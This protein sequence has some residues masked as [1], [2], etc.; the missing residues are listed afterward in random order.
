MSSWHQQLL[1]TVILVYHNGLR[2]SQNTSVGH[3]C[4]NGKVACLVM[5]R[6]QRGLGRKREQIRKGSGQDATPRTR[7]Q[8]PTPSPTKLQ[9]LLLSCPG[10][11]H[12]LLVR[13]SHCIAYFSNAVVEYRDQ[14]QLREEFILTNSFRELRVHHRGSKRQDQE[15]EVTPS[16]TDTNQRVNWN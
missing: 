2:T 15:T 14:K 9:F 12:E 7:S 16:T 3:R 10:R 13:M 4:S 5:A 11:V 1:P 6:K 8:W